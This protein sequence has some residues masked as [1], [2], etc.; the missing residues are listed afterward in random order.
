MSRSASRALAWP[1]RA[2]KALNLC[3]SDMTSS[4]VE[5]SSI[6]CRGHTHVKRGT[7]AADSVDPRIQL[8]HALQYYTIRPPLA[9]G[10]PPKNPFR[11]EGGQHIRCREWY[12]TLASRAA[13][14]TPPSSMFWQMAPTATKHR[15]ACVN[16]HPRHDG[17][18]SFGIGHTVC[19]S[20]C[21][22]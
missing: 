14:R 20:A 22:S 15:A 12:A 2:A 18:L 5:N 16:A 17:S 19:L 11:A 1:S 4:G 21:L 8:R 3:T 10:P 13:A 9:P 6:T 7:P